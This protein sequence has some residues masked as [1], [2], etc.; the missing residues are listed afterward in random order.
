MAKPGSDQPRR[1]NDATGVLFVVATPLGNLDDLSTRAARILREVPLIAAEDTRQTQKLLARLEA[2][3]RLLSLH[4]HSPPSRLDEVLAA[5]ESGSDV[6]LVTDA[7]TPAVSDPGAQMVALARSREVPVVPIPGPSAVATLLSASG[8]PADRYWFA[9]FPPRKGKERAAFLARVEEAT[10]TV[11]CFEA[12]GRVAAL[13]ADLAE[14]VP[15]RIVVL[16]RELT[17]LHEEI[18]HTPAAELAGALA[19]RELKGECTLAIAPGP[20]REA[21]PDEGLAVTLARA[22]R[23]QGVEGSRA[24]RIVAQV[25][26]LSRNQSYDL[27]M[28]ERR[29]ESE[30]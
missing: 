2:S 11:V 3:P 19:G 15:E 30:G 9:G 5:L 1:E 26:G 13:V 12:P 10:E 27:V 22:L 25:S 23:E 28:S 8:L 7:G 14:A 4:A 18:L 20:G 24:A 17:K 6:A 29:E 21:A 16:G